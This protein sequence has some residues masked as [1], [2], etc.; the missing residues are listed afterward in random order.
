MNA[1]D[2]TVYSMQS[3][4]Q[5]AVAVVPCR[6]R[7]WLR[8]RDTKQ[9]RQ[10]RYLQSWK[11]KVVRGKVGFALWTCF[12]FYCIIVEVFPFH[13]SY[14]ALNLLPGIKNLTRVFTRGRRCFE[15]Q[16]LAKS[17]WRWL[18]HCIFCTN[19]GNYRNEVIALFVNFVC[20]LCLAMVANSWRCLYRALDCL[21]PQKKIVELILK[22]NCDS[23]VLMKDPDDQTN[24][25]IDIQSIWLDLSYVHLEVSIINIQL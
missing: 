4:R 19:F 10:R 23:K 22:T 20:K 2:V 6:M 18:F 17:R 15:L 5:K 13:L 9:E 24:F 11:G 12:F 7:K 3:Q 1:V 14:V 8:A 25:E 21:Y 16:L